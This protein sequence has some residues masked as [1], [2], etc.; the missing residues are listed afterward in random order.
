MKRTLSNAHRQEAF[1]VVDGKHVMVLEESVTSIGRQKSNHL[2]ISDPHVSRYHAQIRRS[3]EQ[4]I[5]VDLNSTVGTS[6]NGKRVD[7][8][9]LEPGDV[10]SIGG[11]PLIFGI[12]STNIKTVEENIRQIGDTL[13]GPTNATNL[14]ELDQ[15]LDLFRAAPGSK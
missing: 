14:R 15:Y 5:I 12:G 7:H 10:I 11:V 8:A 9:F 3:G 13:T 1:L 4:F 2:I 6:V